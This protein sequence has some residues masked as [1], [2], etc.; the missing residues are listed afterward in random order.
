M[1]DAWAVKEGD[2]INIRTVSDTRRAAIVN[3]LVVVPRVMIYN[4]M[5]DAEIES[6]W[7]HRPGVAEIIKVNVTE[8]EGA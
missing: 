8:V 4:H 1:T 6:L 7:K 5:T 2:K 3:W